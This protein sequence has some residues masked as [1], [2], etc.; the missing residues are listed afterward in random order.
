MQIQA[1]PTV[2]IEKVII[3]STKRGLIESTVERLN[4]FFEL[5]ENGAEP[6]LYNTTT[7]KQHFFD[8]A[9]VRGEAAQ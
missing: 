6:R 3:I 1:K 5:E 2:T 9:I 4:K 7:C 8:V